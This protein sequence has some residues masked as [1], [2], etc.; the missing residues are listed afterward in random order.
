M[1]AVSTYSSPIPLCCDRV[2]AQQDLSIIGQNKGAWYNTELKRYEARNRIIATLEKKWYQLHE[3]HFHLPGEHEICGQ[4]YGA[5]LHYTF[6]ELQEGERRFR[7]PAGEN[8]PEDRNLLVIARVIQGGG[9][10]EDLSLLQPFP[11]RSFYQYNATKTTANY[12]PVRWLVGS[13]P[14]RMKLSELSL[15]A[16]PARPLQKVNDR[17]VLYSDN[18][19]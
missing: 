18:C 6:I 15:V 17:I 10:V 4:K 8:A 13:E 3:Y 5:E 2:S 7:V 16:L 12:N 19:C 14:L 11:P 1:S 9:Q